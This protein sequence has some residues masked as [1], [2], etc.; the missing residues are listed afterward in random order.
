MQLHTNYTGAGRLSAFVSTTFKFGLQMKSSIPDISISLAPPEE[1]SEEPYSPFSPASFV[2]IDDDDESYRPQHLTPPATST[3]PRFPLQLSPLRPPDSL[4]VGTGVKRERFE[5]MLKASKE[6]SAAVGAKKT[7]DLRKE[8]ALKAHKSK[9]GQLR[10]QINKHCF[11]ISISCPPVE[12]RALFLSKVQA[13]PS[14]SAVSLPKTPPE[15]P[16]IFHYTLPSPGLNSPLALFDALSHNTLA[17]IGLHSVEPWVEQVDF[18]LLEDMQSKPLGR[19]GVYAVRAEHSKPGNPMPSLD[20]I[21]AHL[22]SHGHVSPVPRSE[23]PPM[24]LPAFLVSHLTEP[25]QPMSRLPVS[26]GRLQMPARLP[27]ASSPQPLTATSASCHI[28]L[29]ASS[30]TTVAPALQITTTIVP[31]LTTLSPTELSE[32]NLSVLASRLRTAKDMLSTLKRRIHPSEDGLTGHGQEEEDRKERRRSSPAE[33]QPTE[34]SGFMH[35]VLSM[36]GGF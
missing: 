23:R 8:I 14:P 21:S 3:S 27:P 9:Q 35:P 29:P 2:M 30:D 4:V 18:R 15:S 24:R 6:R 20:Q 34:R 36:P 33:M 32:H 17:N 28:L 7:A 26:V 10:D 16:A 31:R 11:F 5:A 13:P 25:T 22:S 12:R 1:I 19:S